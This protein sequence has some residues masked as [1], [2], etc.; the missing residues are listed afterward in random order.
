MS[1]WTAFWSLAGG[2]IVGSIAG[3]VLEGALSGAL[4]IDDP[5]GRYSAVWRP[6][7]PTSYWAR[8]ADLATLAVFLL[9]CALCTRRISRDGTLELPL[10]AAAAG[11]AVVGLVG[12]ATHSWWSL[13]AIVPAAFVARYAARPPAVLSRRGMH[14]AGLC[15]VAYL[16][17]VG[18]AFA[19]LQAHPLVASPNMSCGGGGGPGI[20]QP[21]NPRPGAPGPLE[22]P[23]RPGGVVSVCLAVRN[24]AWSGS[25]TVLGVASAAL[26]KLR[27]WTIAGSAVSIPA[28]QQNQVL[29]AIHITACP[30]GLEGRSAIL[31]TIPLRA[32][33]DGAIT[34]EPIALERPI[35]TR[36]PAG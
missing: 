1:L 20:L 11:L 35:A 28:G 34:T 24:N 17:V 5:G 25:A 23:H 22:Y 14:V 18:A 31:R 36:C 30:A 7:V 15:A 4:R 2:G 27:P 26:P 13:L 10:P 8:A 29:V 12:Y 21:L 9:L 6:F 19:D 3:A 32:R 16:A 33:V